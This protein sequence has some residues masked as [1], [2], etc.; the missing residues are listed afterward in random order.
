MFPKVSFPNRSGV[1]GELLANQDT[2]ALV[3]DIKTDV[4]VAFNCLARPGYAG[5]AND[6]FLLESPSG[7]A[8]N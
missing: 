7:L 8:S 6:P 3:D 4:Q 5:F 1:R 2:D